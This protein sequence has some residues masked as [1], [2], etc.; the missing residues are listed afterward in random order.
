MA[1]PDDD[2]VYRPRAAILRGKLT[3]FNGALDVQV[4]AL[5]IE[6]VRRHAQDVVDL[7]AIDAERLVGREQLMDARRAPLRFAPGSS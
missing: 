7:V 1:V 6:R 3:L 5:R 4:L 2:F